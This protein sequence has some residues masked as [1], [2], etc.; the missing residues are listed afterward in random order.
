MLTDVAMS[1]EPRVKEAER[2][3]NDDGQKRNRGDYPYLFLKHR[4][5]SG[6]APSNVPV[7][8]R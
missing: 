8:A 4:D 6:M 5:A 1:F 3:A 7:L 2:E